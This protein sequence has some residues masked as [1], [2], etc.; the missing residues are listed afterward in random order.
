M[1]FDSSQSRDSSG[2]SR[3]QREGSSRAGS[4]RVRRLATLLTRLALDALLIDAAVETWLGNAPGRRWVVA[5]A[6]VFYALTAWAVLQ[7]SRLAAPGLVT[8]TPAPFYVL[9]GLL[10][11]T[12]S[13]SKGFTQGLVM[14]KQPTPVVLSGISVLV[15]WLAVFRVA[16]LKGAWTWFRIV[17]LALGLYATYAFVMGWM[18]GTPYWDLMHGRSA[19]D[20]LPYWGQG[21]LAG[22]LI[23][24]AMGF[25]RELGT[26]MA[27]VVLTGY[28]RWMIVFALG[29]WIAINAVGQ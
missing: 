4:S 2:A 20:R 3:S 1:A 13:D 18:R 22:G 25:V 27:R 21:A 28:L 19:W 6:V 5:A 29:A 24:P 16:V 9:L 14:L 15:A 8:Q 11:F 12:T 23:L 17:V 10:V 26:S 7:G